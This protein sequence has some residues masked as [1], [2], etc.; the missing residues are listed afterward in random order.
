LEQ[1]AIA[2]WAGP[3]Q[4]RAKERQ[5]YTSREQLVSR[6]ERR[7]AISACAPAPVRRPH[8]PVWP[9]V[10]ADDPAPCTHH[11]R[12]KRGHQHVIRPRLGAFDGAAVRDRFRAPTPG[13]V[14]YA[15]NSGYIAA[16]RHVKWWA[17]ALSRCATARCAGE[18]PGG[19]S[20]PIGERWRVDKVTAINK[21]TVATF[22]ARSSAS[23]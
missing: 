15:P 11:P 23:S 6:S 4:Q 8:A 10:C 7:S 2:Y 20:Q 17:K 19:R 12:A 22:D 3:Y 9:R 14:S 18:E 13:G 21:P 5:D 16:P 1:I